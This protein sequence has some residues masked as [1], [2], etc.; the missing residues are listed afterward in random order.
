MTRGGGW[1]ADPTG[2]TCVV[3]D[4]FQA[5]PGTTYNQPYRPWAAISCCM[6]VPSASHAA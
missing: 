6:P 3:A 2:M 4:G 1:I 5:R